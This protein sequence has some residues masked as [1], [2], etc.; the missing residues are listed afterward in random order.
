[1]TEA[2]R[3]SDALE[4]KLWAAIK[5]DRGNASNYIRL[6]RKYAEVGRPDSITHY[7]SALRIE[8]R[9]D[10]LQ[11]LKRR[12]PQLFAHLVVFTHIPRT[13]G[14]TLHSLMASRC[15]PNQIQSIECWRH[16]PV[17]SLPDIGE[18]TR[19]VHGHFKKCPY[20]RVDREIRRVCLL[21]NPVE[22]ELSVLKFVINSPSHYLYS[23]IN[24][25]G[26]IEYANMIKE[27]RLDNSQVRLLGGSM[28][29]CGYP[30]SGA[31][32]LSECLDIAK[33]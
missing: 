17:R 28:S 19:Y 7:L 27:E 13:A 15:L 16:Y 29:E 8:S 26:L 22:R 31:P 6:A 5:S 20:N 23:K 25:S 1:M 2:E 9:Q 21:R 4:Q 33:Q 24:E 10:W 12:F 11:E 30:Q 3:Y 14:S 18:N 32:S